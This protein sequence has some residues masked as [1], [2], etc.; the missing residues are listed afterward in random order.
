[1]I[2]GIIVNYNSGEHLLK[3]VEEIYGN[4]SEIIIV[5]NASSDGS[6]EAVLC[7]Y[8][9]VRIIRN[10]VNEGFSKG[11]NTGIRIL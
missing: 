5:D 1:M 3:C 11:V 10:P 9:D 4:V 6:P 7:K 2:S 8:H